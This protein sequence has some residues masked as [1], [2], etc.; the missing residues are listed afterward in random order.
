MNNNYK[1]NQLTHNSSLNVS[2]NS[3]LKN[4]Q[5][6]YLNI[7]NI[8]ILN[9]VFFQN[10]V[11]TGQTYINNITMNANLY[12]LNCSFVSTIVSNTVTNN[13]IYYNNKPLQTFIDN[14]YLEVYNQKQ[15]INTNL[16]NIL[17]NFKNKNSF[18]LKTSL[19]L[20]NYQNPSRSLFQSTINGSITINSN[21]I[22]NNLNI[23]S[24]TFNSN[25]NTNILKSN[26]IL[27]KGISQNNIGTLLNDLLVSGQDNY[28]NQLYFSSISGPTTN[29][30]YK[31]INLG[32]STST[33]N[34]QGQLNIINL[35]NTVYTNKTLNLNNNNPNDIGNNCGIVILA[36]NNG[37]LKT[38]D[39]ST[40]FILRAPNSSRDNNI[41]KFDLNNNLYISGTSICA[42][43]NSKKNI[44][45]S[46][47]TQLNNSRINNLIINRDGYFNNLGTNFLNIMNTTILN[48]STIL[49]NFNHTYNSYFNNINI[50][51]TSFPLSNQLVTQQYLNTVINNYNLGEIS[52]IGDITYTSSI[53]ISHNTILNSDVSFY[54]NLNISNI[55]NLNN[56]TIHQLTGQSI[57]CNDITIDNLKPIM[58]TNIITKDCTT[59]SLVSPNL[60]TNTL[61]IINLKVTNNVNTNAITCNNLFLS[62]L[63]NNNNY[64]NTLRAIKAILPTVTILSKLTIS[65]MTILNNNLNTNN[66]IIDK[67]YQTNDLSV[68]T[69]IQGMYAFFNNITMLGNLN[70][71]NTGYFNKNI[72]NNAWF[73][74]N[75]YVSGLCNVNNIIINNDLMTNN[76]YVQNITT[77]S[78]TSANLNLQNCIFQSTSFLDNSNLNIYKNLT[79]NSL[80]NISSV[81]PLNFYNKS[82]IDGITS[83]LSNL[84]ITNNGLIQGNL[85]CTNSNLFVLN[86]STSILPISLLS[87]LN[88]NI[89][90]SNTLTINSNLTISAFTNLNNA[91]YNNLILS[92]LYISSSSK[93]DDDILINNFYTVQNKLNISG[94]NTINIFYGNETTINSNL[95]VTNT[96][97]L[98]NIIT[99]T[100]TLLSNINISQPSVLQNSTTMIN[101]LYVS[102]FNNLSKL[103]CYSNLNVNNININNILYQKITWLS[104]LNISYN[105]I[106]SNSVIQQNTTI[107]S[108][109]YISNISILNTGTILSNL[110]VSGFSKLDNIIS[111]NTITS[112]NLL[113]QEYNAYNKFN[114]MFISSTLSVFNSCNINNLVINDLTTIYSSLYITKSSIFKDIIVTQAN[115]IGTLYISNVFAF[116]LP[117]CNYY[118]DSTALSLPLWSLFITKYDNPNTNN[119]IN[120]LTL[121]INRIP[122]TLNLINETGTPSKP[123]IY[124]LNINYQ[125]AGAIA[126]DF[127]NNLLPVI[128]IS[129]IN[130]NNPTINILGETILNVTTNMT[131]SSSIINISTSNRYTITYQTQDIF[132]NTTTINRYIYMT[133][134]IAIPY[135]STNIVYFGHTTFFNPTTIKPSYTFLLEDLTNRNPPLPDI[136][137]TFSEDMI[138][139]NSPGF[140]IN[141]TIFNY[142]RFNTSSMS[143]ILKGQPIYGEYWED[144]TY[145]PQGLQS[146]DIT[147]FSQD[148]APTLFA[149]PGNPKVLGITKTNDPIIQWNDSAMRIDAFT[150]SAKIAILNGFYLKLSIQVN[151]P[152]RIDIYDKNGNFVFTSSSADNLSTFY[153]SNYLFTIGFCK[154]WYN[155]I[156]IDIKSIGATVIDY[157]A[158]FG[159]N[160]PVISNQ[161]T[162]Y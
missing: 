94:N 112:L 77:L 62:N 98:Q 117:Q 5:I 57:L 95:Y 70:I 43:V 96:T 76:C 75:L 65:N 2:G 3:I 153:S 106:L 82:K 41:I 148:A 136:T 105:T 157:I 61:Q 27:I 81:N 6:K 9:N 138:I 68:N 84:N 44:F 22:C 48:N 126:T 129:I 85:I 111:S 162:K 21:L 127:N 56:I 64:N 59:Q 67:L 63:I 91:I 83:I 140:M 16:S 28:I 154:Y 38:N 128:I 31:T 108:N 40:D 11:I 35:F 130:N 88:M 15:N 23:N 110:Y 131:I 30:F 29:L 143:I 161:L 90:N 151:S 8:A 53:Y 13:K 101:N 73:N 71:L 25:L 74:T 69:N 97:N 155:G 142:K 26:T 78:L 100:I 141:P 160:W 158:F 115:I 18:S 7:S 137:G 66:L 72:I 123:L 133:N 17:S 32:Q 50:I 139:L 60:N 52:L 134:F 107:N 12:A 93:F 104:S 145:N 51:N 49:S 86:N 80:F 113:G 135:N 92:D 150:S 147:F 14:S 89:Y 156:L 42:M 132:G 46:S 10:L 159:N 36:N 45:I 152:L 54:S 119:I 102:G 47:L 116:N 33:I 146:W 19:Y 120:Q 149:R 79:V 99:N 37:Y 24:G 4:T 39:T 34:I 1:L 121:R 55:A 144:P 109:L 20:N 114:N 122:P 124:P 125:E 103:T 58:L 118:T 87:N